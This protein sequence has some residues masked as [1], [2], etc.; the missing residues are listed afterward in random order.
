MAKKGKRTPS[1]PPSSVSPAPVIPIFGKD[2]LPRE[3]SDRMGRRMLV[4]AGIPTFLG[5][6][7]F[8]SAYALIKY[9]GVQ[10]PNVAVVLVSMGFLGLGVLGITYGGL[11]AS[12]DLGSKGSL[13]GFEEAKVN[14]QRL[15]EGLGNEGERVRSARR[16][17]QTLEK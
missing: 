12:W 1:T 2:D 3:I 4:F 6:L 16:A 13:L 15:K 14:F 8:P 9:G 7:V 10:L 17:S 11:S 5:M